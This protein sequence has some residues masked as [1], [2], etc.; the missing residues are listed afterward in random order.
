VERVSFTPK[1]RVVATV[2]I[3]FPSPHDAAHDLSTIN[4]VALWNGSLWA[5]GDALDRRLWRI[6]PRSARILQTIPLPFPPLHVAAGDGAVW[7]TDQLGDTVARIDPATGRIAAMIR[8]GRGASGVAVGAGSVWAT[9]FLD[10]TVSRID[11][12]T[13]RVVAVISV[14]GSPRDVA[15]GAGSVW[16]ADDGS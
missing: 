2:D 7:V 16:T 6:D 1:P 5:I 14:G 8:I 13:N 9:S 15:V 11:P 3:P 12:H 10:G 4:D